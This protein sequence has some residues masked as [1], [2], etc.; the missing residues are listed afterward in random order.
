MAAK[1]LM[2]DQ[3]ARRKVG[4]GQCFH[5]RADRMNEVRHTGNV[6]QDSICFVRRSLGDFGQDN[7]G[8]HALPADAIEKAQQPMDNLRPIARLPRGE[9][10]PDARFD[11][12]RGF[13]HV[14]VQS[15][16]RAAPA[17]NC[18]FQELSHLFLQLRSPFRLA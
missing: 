4:A 8:D 9:A 18:G 5:R 17:S 10:A 2:F 11:I 12:T 15:V 1:Q 16:D 3:D 6:S 7:V 14:I 13:R